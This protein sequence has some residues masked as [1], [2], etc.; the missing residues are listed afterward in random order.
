MKAKKYI[1]FGWL[2]LS[3]LWSIS[4]LG[5]GQCVVSQ[6]PDSSNSALDPFDLVQVKGVRT[7]TDGVL[8]TQIWYD[9]SIPIHCC[10]NTQ[11]I[12]SR[13]DRAFNDTV[14]VGGLPGHRIGASNTIIS[15][16]GVGVDTQNPNQLPSN[17]SLPSNIGTT[18]EQ[19]QQDG[20]LIIPPGV[21]TIIFRMGDMLVQ[22]AAFYISDTNTVALNSSV[23]GMQKI[24]EDQGGTAGLG[25]STCWEVPNSLPTFGPNDAFRY[26]RIRVYHYDVDGHANSSVKWDIGKGMKSIKPEWFQSVS[27]PDLV[28]NQPSETSVYCRYAYR[29][30]R[31]DLFDKMSGGGLGNGFVLD[32]RQIDELSVLYTNVQVPGRAFF[33]S[34]ANPYSWVRVDEKQPSGSGTMLLRKWTIGGAYY[35]LGNTQP[36]FLTVFSTQDPD[37]YPNAPDAPNQSQWTTPSVQGL[38]SEDSTVQGGNSQYPD[39]FILDGWLAIPPKITCIPFRIGGNGETETSSLWVGETYRSMELQ[40]T[41]NGPSNLES[42]YCR[43]PFSAND[44]KWL[45]VR[46]YTH[47]LSGDHNT[48]V[49]WDMGQGFVPIPPNYLDTASSPNDSI[50]PNSGVVNLANITNYYGLRDTLGTVWRENGMSNPLTPWDFTDDLSL[51]ISYDTLNPRDSFP[52]QGQSTVTPGSDCYTTIASD[53]CNQ[54]PYVPVITYNLVKGVRDT[55]SVL[56]SVVDPN[57]GDSVYVNSYGTPAPG[58]SPQGIIDGQEIDYQPSPQ[59]VGSTSFPFEVCDFRPDGLCTNAIALIII[60]E[61]SDGDKKSDQEDKDDDNDGIPDVIEDAYPDEFADID[62]DGLVNRLDLDSDN[63]GIPDIIEGGGSD[64]DGDGKVQLISGTTFL[65]Y[66]STGVGQDTLPDGWADGEIY[67]DIDSDGDGIPDFLD[68]DSDNDGMYDLE[69]V[70]GTGTDGALDSMPTPEQMGWNNDTTQGIILNIDLYRDLDRDSIPERL[71]IDADN[72]GIPNIV[73]EGQ[74]DDAGRISINPIDAIDDYGVVQTKMT[75]Q[76]ADSDNDG[77]PNFMDLDSDNDGI[78]DVSEGPVWDSTQA[79]L[80]ALGVMDTTIFDDNDDGLSDRIVITAALDSDGDSIPDFLDLDSDNDGI[81]DIAE[82]GWRVI[83]T[84]ETDGQVKDFMNIRQ[85]WDTR[86]SLLG[87]FDSDRDKVPDRLDLDSDND[88][89]PDVLEAGIEADISGG[90]INS[91]VDSMGASALVTITPPDS[92]GDGVMDYLDID[93]DQDGLLD[94][95]EAG[96]NLPPGF[97]RF[98]T[99]GADGWDPAQAQ[100]TLMDSDGDGYP[101]H[102]DLDADN[103]GIP[104][105]IESGRLD[106]CDRTAAI[107]LVPIVAD[108]LDTLVNGLP[109]W[110]PASRHQGYSDGWVDS[111][112][113]LLPVNTDSLDQ[114]DYLDKDSDNDGLFDVLEASVVNADTDGDGEANYDPGDLGW[115]EKFIKKPLNTDAELYPPGI[116]GWDTLPDFRDLD[117]DGDS[118]SDQLEVQLGNGDPITVD[119]NTAGLPNY[120]DPFPC[121]PIFVEAFTPNGDGKNEQFKIWGIEYFPKNQFSVYNRWGNKVF[122]AENYPIDGKWAGQ[123][124][125]PVIGKNEK[126]PEGVYFYTFVDTRIPSRPVVLKKG[127]VYILK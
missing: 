81:F 28:D 73:E 127:F 91:P 94:A 70:E 66:D 112:P 34:C 103:D 12:Q 124:N 29:D 6:L 30:A 123:S 35:V 47:D 45:R 52:C 18:H 79:P 10:S 82:E 42:S 77:T 57:A 99:K 1:L 20:W 23:E 17:Q 11:S 21:D 51:D 25:D 62:G 32:P 61:D 107:L 49:E 37:N 87:N 104:D 116:E 125:K 56:D 76:P 106:S 74:P 122:E 119:C 60:S 121:P 65:L 39:Q 118:L 58:G 4:N 111:L 15:Y 98:P 90:R 115:S 96:G 69:E 108:T 16:P 88:G 68:R 100:N 27:G 95:I 46:L 97:W 126:L 71:D 113:F 14:T 13:F 50:P 26:A 110:V 64:S 38:G 67:K 92:D 101:D 89:I 8:H 80:R 2:I 117:S 83:D 86:D 78:P 24:L 43:P 36:D 75:G 102:L 114:P 3:G 33:F 31:Q 22:G 44:W 85:G 109:P 7:Q 93:S 72:D 63:D 19:I 54:P 40:A 9:S 105:I 41:Y 53:P 55:L 120:R 84:L 5:Y 48:Y 59:F